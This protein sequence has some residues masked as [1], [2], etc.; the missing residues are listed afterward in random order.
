[1]RAA[2]LPHSSDDRSMKRPAA[3]LF[4]LIAGMAAVYVASAKL[5]LSLAFGAEQV[6]VVWPPTGIAL[7]AVLLLGRRIWPG[8]LLGAFLANFTAHEPLGTALG[9]GVGNTL[10]ALA[11]AYLLQR[12]GDFRTTLER[13]KDVTAFLVLAAGV[14]AVVSATIGAL[15]LCLGGVQPWGQLGSLWLLWW[16][17]DA[18]GNLIFAPLLLIWFSTPPAQRWPHRGA[19][20]RLLFGLALVNFGIFGG[21]IPGVKASYPVEYAVFPLVIGAAFARGPLGA[22]A[23]TFVTSLIAIAGTVQ[24]LGPFSR[25]SPAENLVLLQLFMGVVATTGLLLGAVLSERSATENELQ[26]NEQRSRFALEAGAVGV[27]DWNIRTGKVFW[28]DNMFAIHHT[29]P[30]AGERTF[31]SFMGGVHPEDRGEVARVVSRSLESG[32]RYEMEYRGVTDAGQI[33]WFAARGQVLKDGSGTPERMIGVCTDVTERK[34]LEESL[35]TADRQKDEFVAMLAH[36]LR[37]PLAPIRNAAKLLQFAG[38]HGVAGRQLE[39]IERQAA[40]MAR[41]LD[42]L[43]DVSRITRGKVTLRMSTIDLG[44]AVVRAADDTRS[45]VERRRQQLTVSC[46]DGRVFVQ[47]DPARLYQIASNLLQNASKYTEAGG[48]IRVTLEAS[49]DQAV[50]RVADTGIGIEPSFLP[51]IFEL[52]SQDHTSAARWEGGLGIGL[53]MVK[54]LVEMHDG[55]ITALSE[56]KGKGSEFV[57]RLP[58]VPAPE[59]TDGERSIAPLI[60]ASSCRVL[61]ADDNN[62]AARTLA[63]LTGMWGHEVH[64]VADG[65]AALQA[66]RELKPDVILLD[67]GM[68]GMDGYEAARRLRGT[69]EGASVLLVA[70]TGYGREEDRRRATDAGFDH[71]CTKPVDPE[72]LRKLLAA[73]TL[74]RD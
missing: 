7:A 57:V 43:L 41:L 32:E 35:R 18:M 19:S 23:A 37:N 3:P 73:R 67:I 49:P 68:P 14:S 58:R 25:D 15:S 33:S 30:A 16:L 13:V 10:E 24:G 11:G 2:R 60:A 65:V 70:V 8:I 56:G 64:T 52:F 1:M 28:S 9:I 72:L 12:G 44:E 31:D 51:R 61:I 21:R 63:E 69:P 74:Q 17:G 38:A 59:P 4:L 62:D 26:R 22:A 47:A 36:E 46:E 6:T 71:H 66:A 54:S 34:Q 55:S 50:L 5:G 48:S 45:V 40:H 53:T 42:D 27:F 39:V 20:L 29:T